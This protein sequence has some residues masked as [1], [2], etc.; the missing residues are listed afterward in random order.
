[1]WWYSFSQQYGLA[2]FSKIIVVRPTNGKINQRNKDWTDVQHFSV[3]LIFCVGSFSFTDSYTISERC[4]SATIE[5]WK[6]TTTTTWNCMNWESR[7]EDCESTQCS[8]KWKFCTRG[9]NANHLPKSIADLSGLQLKKMAIY[10]KTLC[11]SHYNVPW[12]P[13][14]SEHWTVNTLLCLTQWT[15]CWKKNGP[16]FS[17]KK[18]RFHMYE[19]GTFKGNHF[20]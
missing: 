11:T 14:Y 19:N 10:S 16:F 3:E 4:C 6:K 15:L 8:I 20:T 7:T 1:M 17:W 2:S 12:G 5:L 9:R 18:S 13:N